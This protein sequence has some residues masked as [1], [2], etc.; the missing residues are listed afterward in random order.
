MTASRITGP[1]GLK[2]AEAAGSEAVADASKPW[3]R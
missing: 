2:S 1:I 3:Y